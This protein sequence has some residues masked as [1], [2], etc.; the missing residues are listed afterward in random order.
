MILGD[1]HEAIAN[2]LR[3]R[4]GAGSFNFSAY[5][6][7]TLDTPSVQVWPGT[8][9]IDHAGTMGANGL[10]TM[11]LR[12]RAETVNQD[13]ETAGSIMCR[14]LSPGGATEGASIADALHSD[15]TLGGVIAEKSLV[16]QTSDWDVDPEFYEQVGWV[17][18]S[19]TFRKS[20]ATV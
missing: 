9:Y 7:P 3:E 5:P 12:I 4:I 6:D 11:N 8:P 20:G 14:L 17:D 10:V 19:I 16:T 15:R 18:V 1:I 2:Q 13:G